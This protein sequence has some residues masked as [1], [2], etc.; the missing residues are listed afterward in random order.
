MAAKRRTRIG[1]LSTVAMV[2]CEIA[3]IYKQSRRGE[4]NSMEAYRYANVL[5]V[6]AR[7]LETTA[8]E[9]RLADLE[10]A[11]AQRSNQPEPFKPKIVA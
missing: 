5:A 11:V 7:C 6:L 10:L 8:Y 1:R 4:L 2:G 3:R 9:Q